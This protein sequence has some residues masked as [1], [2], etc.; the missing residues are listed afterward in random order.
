MQFVLERWEANRT[1]IVNSGA[2][3]GTTLVTSGL[4]FVY[5]W[6]AARLF[7]P[8]AVGFASAAISMMMLFGEIGTL[9]LGTMLIGELPRHPEQ[10]RSLISTAMLVAGVA[11]TCLGVLVAIA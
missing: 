7:T 4:W 9:G 11:A 6:F 3:L 2:M 5:L 8:A 1:L 10:S